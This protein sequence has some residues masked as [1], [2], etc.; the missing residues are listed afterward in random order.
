MSVI[1]GNRGFFTLEIPE[2]QKLLTCI[3]ESGFKHHAA[4][5]L[6]A[7][8]AAPREMATRYFS[9]PTYRHAS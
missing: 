8:T 7:I 1:L 4:T 6:S 5:N 2:M 9:S 3:C